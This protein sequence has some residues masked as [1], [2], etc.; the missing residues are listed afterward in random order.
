[1]LRIYST[2]THLKSN[3]WATVMLFTTFC[4]YI[5]ED[6]KTL[7]NFIFVRNV[8]DDGGSGSETNISS[9]YQGW[10]VTTFTC[11][12]GLHYCH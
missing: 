8:L 6:R 12:Q 5:T 2:N 7:N 3:V 9:Y 4:M 1:M 11:L 10:R